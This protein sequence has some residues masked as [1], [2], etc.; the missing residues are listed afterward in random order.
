MKIRTARYAD[1]EAISQLI[2][3]L[4][5]KHILPGCSEQGA[6]ILLKS[7]NSESIENYFSFGYQYWLG[8]VDNQLMAVI[9]IKE[10]SHLYHLFV[11]DPFQGRGHAQQL[12]QHA[13]AECLA[14]GNPGVF[15]VN[16]ALNA[17][18]V[19]RKWGF[20]P[21]C[22]VRER[23]GIKDIPMRLLLDL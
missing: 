15:T 4:V 9:G 1:V 2:A 12:W 19:Y 5:I 13:K 23:S 14:S 21:L 10:N 16:S 11:A 7:M 22:E 8:E 3:P 17:A 6:E 20:E 18:P